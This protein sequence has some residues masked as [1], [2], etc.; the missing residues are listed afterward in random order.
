MALKDTQAPSSKTMPSMVGR[1]HS[2]CLEDRQGSSG[3]GRTLGQAAG[4]RSWGK[5][6]RLLR[7]GA[8][9][10]PCP[11]TAALYPAILRVLAWLCRAGT[12][13][14]WSARGQGLQSP[15]KRRG[16]QGGQR[17]R[18]P[19]WLQCHI[20]CLRELE[21][22][23]CVSRHQERACAQSRGRAPLRAV[24]ARGARRAFCQ[25]SSEGSLRR[26]VG[27]CSR[28]GPGIRL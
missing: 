16:W 5:A 13:R 20:W 7:G 12:G 19:G 26:P 4:A 18:G 9:P 8:V 17:Y 27:N 23:A 28:A 3:A 6:W 11:A 2:K 21:Q 15:G 25:A 1:S 10:W 24:A 14:M 22:R